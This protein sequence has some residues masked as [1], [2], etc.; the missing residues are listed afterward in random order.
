[1]SGLNAADQN[2]IAQR[3]LNGN[4]SVFSGAQRAPPA[5]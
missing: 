3:W 5:G 1:V 2:I 4:L